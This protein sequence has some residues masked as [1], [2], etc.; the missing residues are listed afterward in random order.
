MFE[1]PEWVIGLM[2]GTSAD[3]VDAALIKTDG[4]KS[5]EVG[6]SLLLPYSD[7]ERADILGLMKGQGD[8]AAIAN[9]LTLKHAEAVN[10]LIKQSGMAREDI[11]LIGFHGQTIRH[12][13]HEGITEQ[14]GN[15]PLLVAKTGISVVSDFRSRDVAE[16]GQGAPLVP[17]YH[18][19]LADHLPKPLMVV[20]IGGVANVTYLGENREIL[21]FDCGPGNALMDDWMLHHAATRYDANGEFAARGEVDRRCVENFLRDPFFALPAPKSLDRNHFK[22]RVAEGLTAA[23]GV[24]TLAACTVEAIAKTF[25]HVND[26]PKQ[27]LIT[28]GGRHNTT[29]MA[30]LAKRLPKAKIAPVEEVGWNGDMLEAEAFGYLAVRSARGLA[31]SLP[32]TT[33]VKVKVTGGALY[34]V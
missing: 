18:R 9:A 28:G 31:L 8:R 19:A 25:E 11:K 23:D 32:S 3:G 13:P 26:A 1:T 6:P 15:A 5:V 12:A 7:L 22:S 10:L 21:A 29:L 34:L 2:S 17:L 16:G 4:K 33:G 14:I 20:N 30:M 27:L 24:A